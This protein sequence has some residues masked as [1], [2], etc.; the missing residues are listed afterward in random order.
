[1]TRRPALLLAVLALAACR[2]GERQAAADST[3]VPGDSFTVA[4]SFRTPESVL[5]DAVMDVYVVANING[6]PAD[7]DDNG[8]LSRVSP[9][10]TVV[11]LRWVDGASDGITLN[12]PKGMGIKGDTLFV[13]DIDEVRLFD[14]TTGQP[15]G[16]RPVRGASF[17][18]DITIGPDGTVYVSDTGVRPDFSP[19]GTDAVY[20]FD[21][22]GAPVALARGRALGGPNGLFAYDRG[23]LV[24]TYLSGEVYV[25]DSL[26][27]RTDIQKPPAGGLDGVFMGPGGSVYATSWGDSTVHALLAGDEEWRP[28]L[29]GM[30]TPADIGFDTRRGRILVPI[31][32]GD[33]VE[34]RPLR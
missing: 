33:R 9:N 30:P 20:R 32:T 13:A 22:A 7:K 21:A 14:R 25:L 2:Q 3:L 11:E 34:V 29:R 1:M 5:Y 4:D 12:A 26:G 6:S 23:V 24:V 27:R 10:G 17:L 16:A 15:L 19:A 28:L 18:N 8:F 31:F